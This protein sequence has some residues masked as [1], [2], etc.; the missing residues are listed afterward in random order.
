MIN[1]FDNHPHA[2][3]DN[4]NIVVAINV[5]SGHDSDLLD[6]VKQHHNAAKIVCCCDYGLA[7]VGGDFYEG[8]FYLPKPYQDWI[9]DLE[10]GEWVAPE[11]WVNPDTL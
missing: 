6:A 9:R 3:L 8:K 10:K 4:D 11:G 5:F 1:H 7:V 2:F